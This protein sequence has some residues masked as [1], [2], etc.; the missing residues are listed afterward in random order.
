M[1]GPDEPHSGSD[2]L[3]PGVGDVV[4]IDVPGNI[5]DIIKKARS[6]TLEAI[7]DRHPSDHVELMV[8]AKVQRKLMDL[9]KDQLVAAA[10]HRNPM[11]SHYQSTKK[12]F[13]K[14]FERNGGRISREW[15][16]QHGWRV[17][18]IN[19]E[20]IRVLALTARDFDSIC[21]GNLYMK[22]RIE[23]HLEFWDTVRG[24]GARLGNS[25]LGSAFDDTASAYV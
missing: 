15:I 19:G 13:E 9:P 21:E 16:M 5:A 11:A 2:E 3:L 18:K 20:T 17:L 12:L 6:E 25:T 4:M 24:W 8:R 7:G 10:I 22:K 1:K 14:E 23:E